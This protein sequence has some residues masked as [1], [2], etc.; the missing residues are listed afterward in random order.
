M[1][2][3]K[4]VTKSIKNNLILDQVS[5]IF[6]EG[7]VYGLYDDAFKSDCR[8]DCTDRRGDTL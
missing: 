1:I 3:L 8:L 6:E 5:Y 2:E 7:K 4:N